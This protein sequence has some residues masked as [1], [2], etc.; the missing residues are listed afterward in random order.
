MPVFQL[1]SKLLY[2]LMDGRAITERRFEY[3]FGINLGNNLIAVQG[4]ALLAPRIMYA[5]HKKLQAKFG[6]WNMQ[7]IEFSKRAA[8]K[9][10][11]AALGLAFHRRP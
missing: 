6:S 11:S 4:R 8:L 5:K 9:H 10:Y 3:S 1:Y 7:S 2:Q